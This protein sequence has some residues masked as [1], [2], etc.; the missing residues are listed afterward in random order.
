ML[1]IL[2]CLALVLN[3]FSQDFNETQSYD[4]SK[5]LSQIFNL[6]QNDT[7]ARNMPYFDQNNFKP[8]EG[9][10]ALS[11]HKFKRQ[12]RRR[13]NPNGLYGN[14]YQNNIQN[15][16]TG[17]FYERPSFAT[18]A[19]SRVTEA[20]TSIALYD[21]Y[22]CVPRLLC[23]AAGGGLG[24]SNVLQSVT[25]LQPLITLL[26][27]YG[28]ISSNPLFVFGRAVLLG[29]S[30]K[31][32]PA[33]CRYGYPL[34]PTDPE[35]LVHY[36]N[37][38]NG[39]FFRF[40][41]APQKGQNIQQF[42]NHLQGN[43]QNGN[44][45]LYQPNHPE[46]GFNP[47]QQ[48]IGFVPQNQGYGFQRPHEQYQQNYGLAFPYGENFK[49]QKRI[50]NNP[51]VNN[52][53]NTDIYSKWIFPDNVDDNDNEN[54]ENGNRRGKELK[55]PENSNYVS[56]ENH[57]TAFTFPNTNRGVEYINYNKLYEKYNDYKVENNEKYNDF[58]TV[59]VVRGNG[60]P[61]KPEIVKLRPGQSL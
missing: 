24:S 29:M 34:C 55:F 15:Y 38:H 52:A 45:G 35:Q 50:Q 2:P 1:V 17:H 40:F 30:S 58:V 48:N 16:N 46:T 49:I 41:N 54:V 42:Y 31:E 22:Q 36:L 8:H 5:L 39:G 6:E 27:A 60:D 12:K 7:I 33:S 61:N 59:Y 57:E 23:E 25:G 44:Y 28:G 4:P 47:H 21:D 3:V 10:K 13:I 37:N 32:N 9:S 26:S 19:I 20:L 56:T 53:Y 43:P 51:N 14:P 18:E 11:L